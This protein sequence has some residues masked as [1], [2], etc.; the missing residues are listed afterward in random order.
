MDPAA[1]AV[2]SIIA[3][4]AR[5]PFQVWIGEEILPL[6]ARTLGAVRTS[7]APVRTRGNNI[8]CF[9]A[10][11]RNVARFWNTCPY[12]SIISYF[13]ENDSK[14]CTLLSPSF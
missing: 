11:L 1:I 2:A 10:G 13:A 3:P 8:A 6:L 5:L 7:N 4:I 14:N 9:K 12:L